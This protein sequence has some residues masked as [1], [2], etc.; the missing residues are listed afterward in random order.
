[1]IFFKLYFVHG[2]CP[3][4]YQIIDQKHSYCIE[5]IS[6]HSLPPVNEEIER[7]LAIHNQERIDVNAKNMQKMY[8]SKDLAEIAQ[9]YGRI[10]YE[11]FEKKRKRNIVFCLLADHCDYEH[12]KSS[13]RQAPRIPLPTGQNIAMG[14]QNWIQVIQAWASEKK[15]FVYGSPFQNSVVGHYTQ[16]VKD[17]A[18][19]I[20]CGLA[21]CPKNYVTGQLGD[22][23]PYEHALSSPSKNKRLHDCGGL[24]CLY[25]GKIDLDSCQCQ[26]Q[27]HADGKQCEKLECTYLSN[28]CDYGSDKSLCISYAN[29]LND[30]PKFCGLC[31]RYDVIKN[32]YDTLE[33]ITETGTDSKD[34][35]SSVSSFENVHVLVVFIQI[36]I[37]RLLIK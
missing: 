31:D 30:C 35:S 32:Y 13:Q 21:F 34:A 25:N 19:L 16:M 28:D 20:G 9:R 23:K 33:I 6:S 26:C 27:T 18:T 3:S 29:V 11:K 8:W 36:I 15:D 10:E 22:N 24:V 7:I 17:T 12:D 4:I 37:V 5:K 1:M 2:E 14:Y